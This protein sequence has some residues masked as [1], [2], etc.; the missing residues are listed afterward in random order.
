MM[1]PNSQ[2]STTT[3]GGQMI[4]TNLV[5]TMNPSA[6]SEFTWTN[7]EEEEKQ[8]TVTEQDVKELAS[9]ENLLASARKKIADTKRRII[10]RGIQTE[11]KK[12][13]NRESREA[14]NSQVTPKPDAQKMPDI[15]ETQPSYIAPIKEPINT[16]VIREPLLTSPDITHHVHDAPISTK[17]DTAAAFKADEEARNYSTGF[18]GVSNPSKRQDS[19]G[20]LEFNSAIIQDDNAQDTHN[21]EVI[22]GNITSYEPMLPPKPPEFTPETEN[23]LQRKEAAPVV[24][25]SSSVKKG[26]VLAVDSLNRQPV[27][28]TE[29]IK[30]LSEDQNTRRY[31]PPMFPTTIVQPLSDIVL[32]IPRSDKQEQDKKTEEYRKFPKNPESPQGQTDEDCRCFVQAVSKVFTLD[33]QL[34][35]R[36]KSVKRNWMVEERKRLIPQ[37]HD[38]G[39]IKRTHSVEVRLKK[40]YWQLCDSE[41]PRAKG[42]NYVIDRRSFPSYPAHDK[43]RVASFKSITKLVHDALLCQRGA[44]DIINSDDAPQFIHTVNCLEEKKIFHQGHGF[45]PTAR[46]MQGAI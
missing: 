40:R 21:S 28:S 34:W 24:H 27:T 17:Q 4:S 7:A 18:S 20:S 14:N 31:S 11:N 26:G 30:S 41:M 10:S 39:G 16:S 44:V 46:K 2:G 42:Y 19:P 45:C 36:D 3:I 8:P 15:P 25:D 43:P 29:E 9:L 33:E 1:P 5:S 6:S 32:A 38:D 22:G 37:V 23:A 12:T 35:K 13:T